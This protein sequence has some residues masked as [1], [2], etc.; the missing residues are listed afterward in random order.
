MFCLNR[1]S[2]QMVLCSRQSQS[3]IFQIVTILKM[4]LLYYTTYFSGF[5][6]LLSTSVDA[7][8]DV[9]IWNIASLSGKN[10]KDKFPHG[11]L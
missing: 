2:P 9:L 10:K 3:G 4:Y 1:T 5:V 7:L 11:I 6:L 8:F